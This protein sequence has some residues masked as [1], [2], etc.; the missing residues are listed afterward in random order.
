MEN[1]GARMGKRCLCWYLSDYS[2]AVVFEESH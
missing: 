2:L 1:R